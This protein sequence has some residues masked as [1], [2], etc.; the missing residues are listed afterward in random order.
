M[1]KAAFF[2]TRIKILRQE[3]SECLNLFKSHLFREKILI[4]ASSGI[5]VEPSWISSSGSANPRQT[6]YGEKASI[7]G[8]QP[9]SLRKNWRRDKACQKK[10]KKKKRGV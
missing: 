9:K 6:P 5:E 1:L 10:E 2:I 4:V 7:F 3:I 8:T